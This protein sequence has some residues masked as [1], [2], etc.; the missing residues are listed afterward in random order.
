MLRF[1]KGQPAKR[2]RIGILPAAFNPLTRA[3]L[4]LVDAAEA[5]YRL[6]QAVLLLPTE[7]PHKPYVG[8]SFQDRIAMLE[9]ALASRPQRAI[10]AS[11]EGLFF[12]IA[13][14]FR[15]V[16]GPGV[17]L[18]LLCGRD[19]A[20]RIA[21]WDYGEGPSFSRQLEEF[22]MLVASRQGAFRVP[23]EYRERMHPVELPASLDQVSASSV[24]KAIREGGPWEHLVP[25]A[26]ARR[27][28]ERRLYQRRDPE[29]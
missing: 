8:A 5:Q 20:E 24:R 28:R 12:R 19:A 25:P 9:E 3:H 7:F 21:G 22:Q 18:F 17:E 1:Y 4:A 10:A 11:E 29:E 15:Q 2:G 13:G 16:C 23:A 26:V 14:A 6:D 27:I